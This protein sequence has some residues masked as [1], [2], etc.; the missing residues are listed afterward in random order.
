[1]IETEGTLQEMIYKHIWRLRN[2]MGSPRRT[3][4]S[5]IDDKYATTYVN[6]DS[7]GSFYQNTFQKHWQ[8]S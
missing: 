4:L 7:K 1:M 2:I 5:T 8:I 6:L 3:L